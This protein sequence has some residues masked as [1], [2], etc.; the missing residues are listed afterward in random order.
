MRVAQTKPDL[1]ILVGPFVD[2]SQPI[3]ASG[4]AQLEEKDD[5][6]KV[7]QWRRIYYTINTKLSNLSFL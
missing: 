6:D 3:L 4:D 2:V 5:N 1:L 7:P